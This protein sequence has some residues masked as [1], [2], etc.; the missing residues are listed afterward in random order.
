MVSRSCLFLSRLCIDNEN[1][2]SCL[3]IHKDES[4]P[5]LAMHSYLSCFGLRQKER[6]C[7]VRRMLFCSLLEVCLD[8]RP[9]DRRPD[10]TLHLHLHLHL[11]LPSICGNHWIN[12][13]FLCETTYHDVGPQLHLDAPFWG[14]TDGDIE[15]NDGVFAHGS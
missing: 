6:A 1:S 4:D 12:N 2:I 15:E 3:S 9:V 8:C 10:Y 11:H 7:I 14:A 13:K 5:K